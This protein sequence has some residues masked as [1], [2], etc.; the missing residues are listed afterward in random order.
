MQQRRT[1]DR[2]WLAF[3]SIFAIG[4]AVTWFFTRNIDHFYGGLFYAV[5]PFIGLLH[6]HFILL[7]PRRDPL[8]TQQRLEDLNRKQHKNARTVALVNGSMLVLSSPVIIIIGIAAGAAEHGLLGA[9]MGGLVGSAWFIGGLL[10]I[11]WWRRARRKDHHA[12][13]APK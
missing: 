11:A 7:N 6:N 1:C 4:G 12:D 13:G 9:V 2:L 8:K 5:F 10:G 3:S